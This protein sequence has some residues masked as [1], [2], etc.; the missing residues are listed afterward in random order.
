MGDVDDQAEVRMVVS[1]ARPLL[2]G[3]TAD[4]RL[5]WEI[6]RGGAVVLS[7]LMAAPAIG[8]RAEDR[9]YKSGWLESGERVV[10]S[11]RA[12]ASIRSTNPKLLLHPAFVSAAA[13]CAATTESG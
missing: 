2:V 9:R 1:E 3:A 4:A 13:C 5:G 11:R 8:Q 12:L 10:R 7:L 6:L